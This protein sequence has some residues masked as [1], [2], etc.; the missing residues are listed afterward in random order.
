[1]PQPKTALVTGAASGIGAAVVA[2]I[3]DEQLFDS[4]IAVDIDPAVVDQYST[5]AYEMVMPHMVDISEYAAVQS[6]VDIAEEDGDICAVANCAGVSEPG[7]LDE[8]TPDRWQRILDVNLTGAYN[9]ARATCI[10]MYERGVGTFVTVSSGAGQRGSMS[11]G[12]HYSAAKS[13]QFGLVRG[14][15]KQLS[16][17]I[18]VNCVVPGLIETPLTTDSGLWNEDEI[19]A[20]EASLPAQ[21]MG[22]AEEV[23]DAISFLLGPKSSYITGELL[24]VD[25]GAQLS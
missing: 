1:M 18:R 9:V 4:V 8:I 11:G 2:Q 23:A 22:T 14:L 17:H 15:A 3:V 12:V 13:G 10:P 20:F 19:A 21:R 16:P 6:T 5:A 25:G 7:W 24:T